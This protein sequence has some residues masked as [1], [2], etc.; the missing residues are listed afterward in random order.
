MGFLDDQ[1]HH[2]LPTVL[3]YQAQHRPDRPWILSGDQAFSYQQ[4]DTLS[5]R[6]AQGLSRIG[7]KFGDTVLCM[8]QNRVEQ[9]FLWC[10]LS[11]CGAPLVPVNTHYRGNI[12]AYLIND[13]LAETIAIEPEF[14]QQLVDISDD[15]LHLKRVILI[16]GEEESPEQVWEQVSSRYERFINISTC[17]TRQYLKANPQV[18]GT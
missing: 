7:L 6:L 17:W 12:F 16:I 10:A 13:S 14:L 9:V 1:R 5:G 3:S 8:S 2:D 15:L 18:I 4:V 11:K